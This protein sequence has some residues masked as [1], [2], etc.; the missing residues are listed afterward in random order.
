MKQAAGMQMLVAACKETAISNLPSVINKMSR[1]ILGTG[2]LAA[3]ETV[4]E[5]VKEEIAVKVEVPEHPPGF[6]EIAAGAERG[7]GSGVGGGSATEKE[8]EGE[9][10]AADIKIEIE[11]GK[12]YE[13]VSVR[14]EGGVSN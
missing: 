7:E 9:L 1:E 10:W 4:K 14:E 5:E 3:P 11:P 2:N 13:P 8:E 12:I 6:E